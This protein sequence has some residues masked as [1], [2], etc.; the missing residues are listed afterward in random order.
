VCD[1]FVFFAIFLCGEIEKDPIAVGQCRKGNHSGID[2]WQLVDGERHI[3][4]P[5]R[6]VVGPIQGEFAR[7]KHKEE[8]DDHGICDGCLQGVS[9]V[10]VLRGVAYQL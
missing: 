10:K 8:A 2:C 4:K 9:V 5:K 1:C 7:A 6:V 3:L